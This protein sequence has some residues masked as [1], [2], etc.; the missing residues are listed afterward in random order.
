[1][2]EITRSKSNIE[3]IIPPTNTAMKIDIGIT[4]FTGIDSKTLVSQSSNCLRK[5][6]MVSLYLKFLDRALY[7][8]NWLTIQGD[9]T[10]ERPCFCRAHRIWRRSPWGSNRTKLGRTTFTAST[11][12]YADWTLGAPQSFKW[13]SDVIYCVFQSSYLEILSKSTK[14]FFEV[15]REELGRRLIVRYWG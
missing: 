11:L 7:R 3:G 8:E 2:T 5:C 6:F 1:M 4:Q 12:K 10:L 15:P 9:H 14:D 13:T